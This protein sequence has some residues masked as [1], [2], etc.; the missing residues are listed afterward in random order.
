MALRSQV[1]SLLPHALQP[2]PKRSGAEEHEAPVLR[3]LSARSAHRAG[4]DPAQTP[5]RLDSTNHIGFPSGAKVRR[6]ASGSARAAVGNSA[7]G[8]QHR[9]DNKTQREE[10]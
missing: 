9:A 2:S 8:H 5:G 6:A 4:A 3:M 7:P 10:K 1:R